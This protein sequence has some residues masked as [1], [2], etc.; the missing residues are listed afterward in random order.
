MLYAIITTN[1]ENT[2]NQHLQ[3]RPVHLACLETLKNE[4]H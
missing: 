3:A 4:A 1:I 2:L